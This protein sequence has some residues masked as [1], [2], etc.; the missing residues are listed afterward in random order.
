[1]GVTK[2]FKKLEGTTEDQP[3]K[4]FAEVEELMKVFNGAPTVAGTT[5]RKGGWNTWGK[6]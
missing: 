5:T 3:L 4:I 1:M 6:Q 2:G